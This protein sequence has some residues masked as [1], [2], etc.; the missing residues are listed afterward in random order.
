MSG[1]HAADPN[2]LIN[3]LRLILE[4]F[5]TF[6]SGKGQEKPE[7]REEVLQETVERAEELSTG[8]AGADKVASEVEA[9]LESGLGRA[10]KDEIIERA[11]FI[12]A[13][14]QPFD[15]GAFRY[16]ESLSKVL[17]RA[18]DFC[19]VSNIFRLRGLRDRVLGSEVVALPSVGPLIREISNGFD[20][21]TTSQLEQ[22][23]TIRARLIDAFA[24]LGAGA[25][26][27][28]VVL[29]VEVE[30]ATS[31]GDRYRE[32]GHA[33]LFLTAGA[34]INW[35]A[36]EVERA[37]NLPGLPGVELR[38]TAKQ[39]HDLVSAILEDLSRYA[40]ELADEETDFK[41]RIAPALEKVLGAWTK[42]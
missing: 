22:R 31:F 9:K 10:G 29:D 5:K 28:R 18:Q 33:T 36:F 2:L 24:L 37:T 17:A 14:A 7:K 21:I 32:K 27:L 35:L 41:S 13:V 40:K 11:T 26:A 12:L 1:F 30:K 4:G 16:Y 15:L 34:E 38:L 42:S 20:V 6:R 25:R 23:D 8:G 3:A 39:F 19:T